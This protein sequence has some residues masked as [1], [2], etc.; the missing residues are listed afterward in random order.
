[1]FIWIC[2]SDV[3]ATLLSHVGHPH[4]KSEAGAF[5]EGDPERF[6]FNFSHAAIR[7]CVSEIGQHTAS[8]SNTQCM[9]C[10]GVWDIMQLKDFW[11]E[12]RK[13]WEH[14]DHYQRE[15]CAII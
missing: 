9:H 4:V 10:V 13:S 2:D 3:R 6:H 14:W 11:E 7:L 15:A 12:F 8:R 1:M 5:K